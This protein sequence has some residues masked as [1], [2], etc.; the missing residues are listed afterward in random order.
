MFSLLFLIG[1]NLSLEC[2]DKLS[3]KTYCND[4]YFFHI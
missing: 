1:A 3:D 4:I 2:M